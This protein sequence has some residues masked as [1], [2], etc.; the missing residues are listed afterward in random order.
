MIC[1]EGL[2]KND[3]DWIKLNFAI[4]DETQH[5]IF[6]SGMTFLLQRPPKRGAADLNNYS[7]EKLGRKKG[8]PRCG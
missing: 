6:R 2:P 1:F 7:K 5:E 3:D 8:P 4:I